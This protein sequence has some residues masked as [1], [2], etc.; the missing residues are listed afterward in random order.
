MKT[1]L[2]LQIIQTAKNNID[3]LTDINQRRYQNQVITQ[4]D[5]FRTELLA[6]QYEIQLKSALQETSNLQKELG[7]LLGL[8]E[9]AQVETITN[10][11][12]EMPESMD[13]L[14]SKSLEER[15]DI[16]S[17]RQLIDIFDEIKN[18]LVPSITGAL[19]P[20]D[21]LADVT[22]EG[23]QTNIYRYKNKREITVRTNIRDRDQGGFVAE[24]QNRIQAEITIPKGYELVYGGQYENLERA[25]K[26]LMITIPLTL[27]V[28]FA[29]LFM[30][31]KSVKHTLI[32]ISCVLFALAGGIIALLMRGY[33]FNVS[34]GVGFVSIFGISVMSGVLLVSA[35]NRATLRTEITKDL[36]NET[37]KKQLKAVLTILILAILGLVPAA[38]STGIGSDVQRPLATVIIG[39]LT[40]TLIFAPLLIPPLYWWKGKQ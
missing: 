36:V 18:L 8:Q 32:T 27:V 21:Q 24:L 1:V 38:T 39:G 16:R 12:F 9:A 6:K 3:S 30:L 11:I 4:T 26:Q 25:G 31:F 20:M 10:F 14:L 22:F 37:S 40:S 2:E 19:I 5:L 7:F 17:A 33:Y 15:S 23:G 34:A 29:F 28:V 35:L 13:S